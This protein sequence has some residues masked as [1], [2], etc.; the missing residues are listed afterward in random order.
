MIIKAFLFDLDGTLIDS[1]EP[2][3]H[4]FYDACQ[5]L[6]LPR[7]SREL[8]LELIG[9]PLDYMFN[10]LGVKPEQIPAI[11]AAYKESYAKSY[12]S[13]TTLKAGCDEALSL[14]KNS[15][16]KIAAVTTKTSKYS[17]ILL[18]HLGV[19]DYFDTIIGRD[20]VKHP[21]PDKEPVQKALLTLNEEPKTALMIGDTMMDAMSAKAAG[22]MAFG[23]LCGYGKESQLTPHCDKIFSNVL[24]AVE[25]ALKNH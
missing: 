3:V 13:G 25:F 8:I 24:E 16:A 19:G 10:K 4:G 18:D 6:S 2:I 15:G 23:V 9:H 21:K 7:P 11:I 12:L 20:D 17:R 5:A 22:A 1:T 14:A